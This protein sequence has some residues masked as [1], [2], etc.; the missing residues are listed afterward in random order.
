MTA[1]IKCRVPECP[2]FIDASLVSQ[3]CKHHRHR[4]PWCKCDFCKK[5]KPNARV[6][7][8]TLKELI[9]EGLVPR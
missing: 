3:V 6:R 4:R 9:E 2:E 5:P 7:I 8:K 1:R